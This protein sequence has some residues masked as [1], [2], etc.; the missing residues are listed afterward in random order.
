MFVIEVSISIAL[1]RVP[2]AVVIVEP[3]PTPEVIDVAVSVIIDSGRPIHLGL[4]DPDV[5]SQV[6]VENVAAS[7]YNRDDYLACAC[8]NGPGFRGVDVGIVYW[9]AGHLRVCVLAILVVEPPH[10]VKMSVAGDDGCIHMDLV[11]VTNVVPLGIENLRSVA[12]PGDCGIRADLLRKLTI[13]SLTPPGN[14]AVGLKS[15][16]RW[17]E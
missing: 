2:H 6:W 7:V 16:T 10:P 8:M 15:A 5:V 9:I 11:F 3:V 14:A 1:A 13:P 12:Q 17:T 4:V